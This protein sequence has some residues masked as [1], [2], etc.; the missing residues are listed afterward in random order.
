MSSN[1]PPHW[2][3]T[4]ISG[5]AS[6]KDFYSDLQTRNQ[7]PTNLR[8]EHSR[9]WGR[10]NVADAEESKTSGAKKTHYMGRASSDGRLRD[11]GKTISDGRVKANNEVKTHGRWKSEP[12]KCYHCNETVSPDCN[13]NVG[14]LS[15]CA[16]EDNLCIQYCDVT[17]RRTVRTC[18]R[19]HGEG[20]NWD[21]TTLMSSSLGSMA[22]C[23][24][25][26]QSGC[27][28]GMDCAWDAPYHHE[29]ISQHFVV[30]DKHSSSRQS[31]YRQDQQHQQQQE[32]SND[33][34]KE[35]NRN[36]YRTAAE[37][38]PLVDNEYGP[39]LEL[40]NQA[41][42]GN[43]EYVLSQGTR[44]VA[45]MEEYVLLVMLLSAY[46]TT[47]WADHRK[48]R[49]KTRLALPVSDRLTLLVSDRL[50]LP[51]SDQLVLLVS[52]RLARLVTDRLALL[53][54]DR[55]ALPAS[56]QLVLLVSDRLARLVTDRLA[57]P[58]S[59]QLVLLVSDRLALQVSDRLTGSTSI[60]PT[61]S[62][63]L[64]QPVWFHHFQT[65]GLRRPHNRTLL[66]IIKTMKLKSAPS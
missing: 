66:T 10:G 63:R 56:D 61:G 4:N 5:G 41:L 32:T 16:A 42:I 49:V 57:L 24:Q 36:S 9:G 40:E 12:L 45:K 1:E 7:H 39:F 62:T 19:G 51:A 26:T 65:G 50:A 37:D 15:A 58:A 17:T 2:A 35:T 60:R 25:C 47:I 13:R 59:D 22:H 23:S 53:V 28:V 52:D 48:F 34:I 54:S 33:A 44:A 11:I 6:L 31:Q 21:C 27:N 3:D 18:G 43:H 29:D 38:E 55:L 30:A 14:V 64:N 20:N 46:L 8:D